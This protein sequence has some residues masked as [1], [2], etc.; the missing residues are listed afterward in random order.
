MK[1]TTVRFGRDLWELLEAEAELAGVSVSQY[2]R[3]AALARA[4]AAAGARGQDPVALLAGDSPSASEKPRSEEAALP[5]S[6]A[7]ARQTAV[8][9]R[10]ESAA[11]KAEAQQAVRRAHQ[12]ANESQRL[13]TRPRRAGKPVR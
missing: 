2:I 12:L 4:S 9:Q 10:S 5:A 6:A 7:Q 11:T 1:V 13:K 3:E 8:E